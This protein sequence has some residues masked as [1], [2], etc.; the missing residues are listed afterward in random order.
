MKPS[1]RLSRRLILL[2]RRDEMEYVSFITV[3]SGDDLLVSFAIQGLDPSGVKSLT[4][5]RA[6]KRRYYG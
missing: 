1:A 6:E 3:Q 5:L 2:V 4:L